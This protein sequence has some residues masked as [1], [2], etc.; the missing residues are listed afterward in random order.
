ML[1][2]GLDSP[3]TGGGATTSVDGAVPDVQVIIAPIDTS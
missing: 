2:M 3:Q 1:A